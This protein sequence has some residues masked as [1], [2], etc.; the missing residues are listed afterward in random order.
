VFIRRFGY[1]SVNAS[2]AF[3]KVNDEMLLEKLRRFEFK[4]NL[5]QWFQSYLFH[6]RQQITV[7]R[8]TSPTLS[9]TSGV[10]QGSD[11]RSCTQL[12]SQPDNLVPLCKF[13]IITLLISLEIDCFHSQ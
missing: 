6:C 11:P 12:R 4:N 13:E 5:L 10:P 9:V 3:D 1:I 2:K 8:A 7:L